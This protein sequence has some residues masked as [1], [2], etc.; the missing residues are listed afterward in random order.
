MADDALA[1]QLLAAHEMGVR[2]SPSDAEPRLKEECGGGDRAALA[3]N[4]WRVF[5]GAAKPAK[6]YLPCE[7]GL[8]VSAQIIWPHP[9]EW[10]CPC[11]R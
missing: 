7:G 2:A 9:L 8:N 3:L 1:T 4:S 5:I 10:R 11:R 6:F